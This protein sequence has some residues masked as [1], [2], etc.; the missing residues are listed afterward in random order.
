MRLHIRIFGTVQG[1]F[2]RA[3]TRDVAIR[4]G[5]TGYVRNIPDGS[6]E[7]VAEGPKDKLEEFL[8]WC[9]KG[10]AGATVE[11]T[12]FEFS[13]EKEFEDFKILY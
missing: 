8:E 6:V 3:N 10:P 9:K 1:V 4:L 12:D 7:A 2:F 5:L 11:K 13:E